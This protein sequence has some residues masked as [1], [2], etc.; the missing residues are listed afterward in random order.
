M[1]LRRIS[2]AIRIC[3]MIEDYAEVLGKLRQYDGIGMAVSEALKTKTHMAKS[4][5]IFT[6]SFVRGSTHVELLAPDDSG[7]NARSIDTVMLPFD[8]AL[9]FILYGIGSSEISDTSDAFIRFKAKASPTLPSLYPVYLYMERAIVQQAYAAFSTEPEPYLITHREEVIDLCLDALKVY[10][11]SIDPDSRARIGHLF[12]DSETLD[13][14]RQLDLP[15][16]LVSNIFTD[17]E[18]KPALGRKGQ[19]SLPG[20]LLSNAD[21]EEANPL[22]NPYVGSL[23]AV[24]RTVK[25]M[26]IDFDP[27]SPEVLET[28]STGSVLLYT[29]E[30]DVADYVSLSTVIANSRYVDSE[31][32]SIDSVKSL[33]KAY[34]RGIDRTAKGVFI[35]KIHTSFKFVEHKGLSDIV[36]ETPTIKIDR[37]PRYLDTQFEVS[38]IS[39]YYHRLTDR[40]GQLSEGVIERELDYL[41]GFMTYVSVDSA[42]IQRC[43][44]NFDHADPMNPSIYRI[45]GDDANIEVV[46]EKSIAA[47]KIR[48]GRGITYAGRVTLSTRESEEISLTKELNSKERFFLEG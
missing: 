13:A 41:R 4:M 18:F 33:A 45:E 34:L 14:T 31:T 20:S 43:L 8:G 30:R 28:Y 26:F 17:T 29:G 32:L 36:V 23:Q 15:S 24:D 47:I 11:V 5:A 6:D 7:A 37:N 46:D 2:P 9:S 40:Q 35:D 3:R 19:E 27:I 22:I 1:K 12:D 39:I 38:E 21:I 25:R 10:F 44:I 16:A 48:D 42:D